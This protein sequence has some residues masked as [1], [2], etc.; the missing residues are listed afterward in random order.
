MRGSI[1][2]PLGVAWQPINRC[3]PFIQMHKVGFMS[4]PRSAGGKPKVL[5]DKPGARLKVGGGFNGF[6]F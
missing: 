1:G 6:P 2:R 3:K 4:L 5:C